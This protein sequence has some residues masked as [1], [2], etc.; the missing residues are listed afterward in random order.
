MR[1][2]LVLHRE[3]RHRDGQGRRGHLAMGQACVQRDQAV[4]AA[5]TVTLVLGEDS[6]LPESAGGVEELARRLRGHN[7]V[8]FHRRHLRVGF[9]GSMPRAH[10][11]ATS[12]WVASASLTR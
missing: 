12:S 9:A 2:S 7:S 6:P 1:L 3:A 11:A 4:T 10:T 5:E 8:G